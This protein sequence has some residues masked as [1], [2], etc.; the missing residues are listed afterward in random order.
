M[1]DDLLPTEVRAPEGARRME[2]EWSDGVTTAYRHAIL[3]GFCPCAHCQGHHGPVRWVDPAN[4][5]LELDRV[6][7]VGSYALLLGW[8]DG[9]STGIYTFRFLRALAEVGESEA[10]DVADRAF[11]R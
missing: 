7:E 6:E 9:H 8:G 1:S 2:I 4:A 5:N 10:A 11:N 3:R